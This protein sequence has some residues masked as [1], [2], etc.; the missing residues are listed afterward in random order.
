M[1]SRD[2][3]SILRVP[4]VTTIA[5]MLLAAPL[6][7]SALGASPSRSAHPAQS[8]PVAPAQPA[9]L[10][11]LSLPVGVGSPPGPFYMHGTHADYYQS[12][13]EAKNA[14]DLAT[15]PS[16]DNNVY[17]AAAGIVRIVQ[18]CP[19]DSGHWVIIDHGNNWHTG[20]Y[21]IVNIAVQDGHPVAAGAYLG[22]MGVALPCGGFTTG[23]HVHFTLWNYAGTRNTYPPQSAAYPI[24]GIAIGGWVFHNDP[25]GVNCDTTDSACGS[26]TRVTTGSTVSLPR[27]M[28]NFGASGSSSASGTPNLLSNA[29]AEGGNMG[30]WAVT[31][32][33]ENVV[34]YNFPSYAKDGHWFMEMN[35]GSVPVSSGPSLYQDITLSP[36]VGQSY[37][38]SAWVRSAISTPYTGRLVIWGLGG[39][40]EN[41]ITSFKAT[42]GRWTQVS[43]TMS[44][45][46]PGHT[47][48]RAQIYFDTAGQNLDVDGAIVIDAGLSSAS[49][50]SAGSSSG[51]FLSAAGEN[52]RTYQDASYA[53]D[54]SW[55]MEMNNG[56]VP[57]S[58]NPGLGQ[59]I[60]IAPTIGQSFTFSAWVRSPTSTPYT[61]RLAVWGLNGP[62]E[63]A[64]TTFKAIHSAWTFVVVTLEVQQAGHTGM[65]ARIDFDT[66][67][68]NLDVDGASF[69][70]AGLSQPS[71]EGGSSAGWALTSVG[72]N[73]RTY[74]DP[75]YAKDGHWFM[76]MNNGSVP[77]SSGPSL[78]Q[79]V[80]VAPVPGRSYTF[81]V[82]VRSAVSAPYT[83]RLVLWGLGGTSENAVTNFTAVF[84]KWTQVFVTLS[85]GLSG[86]TRLRAEI[87]FD[88]AAQNLDVDGAVLLR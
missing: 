54:G 78:Y 79:D 9:G 3:R 80:L 65:Q 48:L 24:A 52:F 69:V 38:F 51:W 14:L 59:N 33:G 63:T 32:A 73:F 70:D 46:Q 68:Q 13:T 61:G 1:P 12:Q 56:T 57:V 72:E 81:S 82:W 27:Y 74:Q 71:V 22:K 15:S 18:P 20:Y 84:G 19:G 17:A 66:A 50:E 6:A 28:T 26:A 64:S 35:N 30:G 85:P 39:T 76:E 40:T 58:S 77:V 8:A 45:N 60:A 16:G 29:S 53:K 44:V 11:P 5:F 75:A 23:P 62:L 25:N 49:A 55:F 2:L 37:R 4:I 87:Y 88:T 10:P 47:K 67:G 83:G 36:S 21:H 42:H 31:S 86:H 7:G 43:A 34:A 41:A